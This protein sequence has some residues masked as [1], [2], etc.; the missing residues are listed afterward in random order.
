MML[1]LHQ[2][3]PVRSSCLL[4]VAKSPLIAGLVPSSSEMVLEQ[5]KAYAESGVQEVMLQ[6]FEQDNVEGLCAFAECVLP[7]L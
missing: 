6:W 4:L 1:P 3:I 7:Q 2:G 5:L